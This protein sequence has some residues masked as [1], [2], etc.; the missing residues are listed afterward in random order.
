[1]KERIYQFL[2]WLIGATALALVAVVSRGAVVEIECPCPD[3]PGIAIVEAE[4][5]APCPHESGKCKATVY[6]YTTKPG[7]GGK[8]VTKHILKS[9]TAC[10]C[11]V[12]A[13][14]CACIP[15]G[16]YEGACMAYRK[17]GTEGKPDASRC[18]YE[19]KCKEIKP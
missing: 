5:P 9:V 7:D 18:R 15:N 8:P 17:D 1:M 16:E 2:L 11:V 10:G 4:V 6:D 19:I 13:V 14:V 12:K 3:H